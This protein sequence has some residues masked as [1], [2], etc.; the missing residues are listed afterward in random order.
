MRRVRIVSEGSGHTTKI[1][2][3]D[4]G[5]ELPVFSADIH[6]EAGDVNRATLVV[7]MPKVDVEADAAIIERCSHCGHSKVQL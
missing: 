5:T 4:T 1:T 3:V 2:E 6:I 7:P